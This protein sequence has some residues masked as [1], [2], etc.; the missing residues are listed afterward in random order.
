MGLLA[1]LSTLP[2]LGVSRAFAV[3]NLGL[4]LTLFVLVAVV[5]SRL[6]DAMAREQELAVRERAASER[7]RELNEMQDQLMRSVAEDAREPLGDIYAR[8][9]T[10]GFDMQT[11]TMHES[12]EA[13]NE[14]ADASRRLSQLVNT[15]LAE[16]QRAQAEAEPEV[17]AAP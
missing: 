2:P 11:L 7:I 1:D 8:V 16:D 13:L 15:L 12:R 4:R 10:L 9:V 3:G 14:I 17:A 6:H 5:V